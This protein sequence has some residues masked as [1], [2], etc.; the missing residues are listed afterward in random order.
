MAEA[1]DVFRSED[2]YDYGRFLWARK[3]LEDALDLYSCS[4]GDTDLGLSQL[5]TRYSTAKPSDIWAATAD[6]GENPFRD[7]LPEWV[8]GE[9]RD[10]APDVVGLSFAFDE[11]LIPGMT[12]A[13]H[14]KAH[15]DLPVYA[16]GS[17]VTRLKDDLPSQEPFDSLI[18]DY[19]PYE[20]EAQFGDIIDR[21]EGKATGDQGALL[22]VCPDFDDLP[23]DE[24]FLPTLILP[25]ITSRGCS[26]GK[27]LYCVHYKTYE[28]FVYGDAVTTVRHLRSLADRY[29][30]QHFHFVDEA[31]EPR[32]G[33]ELAKEL[34]S[35]GC[36]YRW[37]VFGR[38]HRAWTLEVVQTIARSGCRRLIFGLDAATDR[39]QQIMKKNTDLKHAE[40]VLAWC[41]QE[42]IAAQVNF[43][44]GYPTETKEEALE[45]LRFIE[46]NRTSLR[47]VGVSVAVSNF[48]MVRGAG[49]DQMSAKISKD[50]DKPFQIYYDYHPHSGLNM[51]EAA[52]LGQFVQ[53]SADRILGSSKRFPLLREMAFLYNDRFGRDQ[54]VP[55]TDIAP[56]TD[57]SIQW[58]SHDLRALGALI[59][60]SRAGLEER[61]EEYLSVWWRL[62]CEADVRSISRGGDIHGYQLSGIFTDNAFELCIVDSFSIAGGDADPAFP[63]PNG[64]SG[65]EALAVIAASAPM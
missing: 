65:D 41:A 29:H 38:I 63:A 58:F 18:D 4:F 27:C 10:F 6:S 43:I 9:I 46:R 7:L 13:R 8:D 42:R 12:V 59:A 14:V 24:Y 55:R 34:E 51:K 22:E 61:A 39:L 21:L 33:R 16:G 36:D 53:T 62:A 47:T 31:L 1:I 11:Q 28:R 49:L 3:I 50:S 20:S 40:N 54:V 56:P 52:T 5:R 48:A 37:M 57:S 17:M 45:A 25:Y 44:T 30:C 23:L 19:L 64:G 2:F 26:F 35:H 15:W 32:F 60:T